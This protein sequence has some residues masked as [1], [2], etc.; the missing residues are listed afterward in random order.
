M[1]GLSLPSVNRRYFSNLSND[2]FTSSDLTLAKITVVSLDVIE[3]NPSANE[4]L[5]KYADSFIHR[6][7]IA[8]FL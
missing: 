3:S 1:N 7:G 2:Y 4:Y 5:V 8:N 6:D